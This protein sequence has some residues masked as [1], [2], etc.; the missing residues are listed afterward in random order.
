MIMIHKMNRDWHEGG[1]SRELREQRNAHKGR[2]AGFTGVGGS[3]KR[4]VVNTLV[5][6]ELIL[7]AAGKTPDKFCISHDEG[8]Q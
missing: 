1:V 6:P 7:L 8:L 2:V 3:G 5:S 4:T